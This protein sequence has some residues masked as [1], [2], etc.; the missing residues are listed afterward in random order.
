ME[1]KYFHLHFPKRHQNGRRLFHAFT[2]MNQ[3]RQA[4]PCFLVVSSWGLGQFPGHIGSYVQDALQVWTQFASSPHVRG[5]GELVMDLNKF[6]T[7][8]GSREA[9]E[10]ASCD[11]PH[12]CTEQ[13]LVFCC[14]FLLFSVQWNT[15]AKREKLTELMFEHYNIPAFFL[16]KSAVLS[17][18]PLFLH[19][20][21]GSG[22]SLL[23]VQ[24][25]LIFWAVFF[26]LGTNH[27][28][29]I[30]HGSFSFTL[31]RLSFAN[32]RSTGLVLDSGATHTTA[33]PVHDGYVLQQGDHFWLKSSWVD[34]V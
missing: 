21:G 13:I 10:F 26:L 14:Y 6:K 34:R 12:Q 31:G 27:I 1:C 23:V 5:I 3:V 30:L 19:I 16:C 9:A 7:L 20:N 4:H 33:I 17:A 2:R 18:Y 25:N 29:K 11:D 8:Y 24:Y 22:R 32:G 15:R 28:G